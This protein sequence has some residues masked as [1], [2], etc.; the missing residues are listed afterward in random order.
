MRSAS[1]RKHQAQTGDAPR[2]GPPSRTASAEPSPAPLRETTPERPESRNR[3]TSAQT[4]PSWRR[5]AAS[6]E[7]PPSPTV[8]YHTQGSATRREETAHSTLAARPAPAP[9]LK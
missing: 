1:S 9:L 8:P 4:V 3:A 7:S 5:R 2:Y 6:P